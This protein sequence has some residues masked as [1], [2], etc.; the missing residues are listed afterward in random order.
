M[1]M[2]LASAAGPGTPPWLPDHRDR[3]PTVLCVKE[4]GALWV[5]QLHARHTASR[6]HT[7]HGE[8]QRR[9]GRD[10]RETVP[11]MKSVIPT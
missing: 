10:S 2:Q 1:P 9:P 5:E 11:L 7:A 4:K 3:D 6:A 8:P